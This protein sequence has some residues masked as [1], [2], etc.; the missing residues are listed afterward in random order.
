[1]YPAPFPEVVAQAAAFGFYHVRATCTGVAY[2]G[3]LYDSVLIGG[4]QMHNAWSGAAPESEAVPVPNTQSQNIS[5]HF[6]NNL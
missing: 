2:H 6:E 1:M 3:L 5:L 4:C